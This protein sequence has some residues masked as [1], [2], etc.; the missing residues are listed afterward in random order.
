MGGGLPVVG[1]YGYWVNGGGCAG[2]GGVGVVV[3]LHRSEN[4]R[5]FCI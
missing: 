3:D 4:L 1:L 2:W 5:I